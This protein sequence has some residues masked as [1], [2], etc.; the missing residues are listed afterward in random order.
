MDTKRAANKLQGILGKALEG[1][2][3]H[4]FGTIPVLR[5]NNRRPEKGEGGDDRAARLFA[6][7]AMMTLSPCFEIL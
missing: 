5:C 2:R 4:G 3:K 1:A 7:F 6:L